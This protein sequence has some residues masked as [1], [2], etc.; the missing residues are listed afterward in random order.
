MFGYR[1][2]GLFDDG[3]RSFDKHGFVEGL[4]LRVVG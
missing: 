2:P 3:A 1:H 4:E